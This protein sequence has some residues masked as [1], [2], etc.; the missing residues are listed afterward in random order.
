MQRT[1]RDC[2]I[3][4]KEGRGDAVPGTYRRVRVDSCTAATL[5]GTL[6]D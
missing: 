4:N 3:N 6:V 2:I 5:L 1:G